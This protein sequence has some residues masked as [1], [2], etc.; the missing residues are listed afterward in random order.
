MR[1]GGG[2]GP[3]SPLGGA[4]PASSASYLAFNCAFSSAAV[5]GRPLLG[6]DGSTGDLG[7]GRG[8]E[9]GVSDVPRGGGAGAL[10]GGA[11]AAAAAASW[12]SYRLRNCSFSERIAWPLGAGGTE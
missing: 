11:A 2:G 10:A 1:G 4:D 7:T 12:A 9:D 8:L 6:A 5:K 3:A